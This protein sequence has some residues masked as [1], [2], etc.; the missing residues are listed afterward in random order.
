MTHLQA[1]RDAL[2]AVPAVVALVDSR[3]YPSAA[4]QGVARPFVVLRLISGVPYHTHTGIPVEL[5]EAARVQVDSYGTEYAATHALATALDD[6][7]GAL[8]G[9]APALS[10]TREIARDGYEDETSLYVVSADYLV[11]R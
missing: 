2:L 3:V 4:P 6:V 9:P 11:H 5:L 10:A 1:V 7:L 8:A